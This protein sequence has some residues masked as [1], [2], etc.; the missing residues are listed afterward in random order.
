[1]KQFLNKLSLLIFVL[2]TIVLNKGWSIEKKINFK[3]LTVADG[4]SQGSIYAIY[5]DSRGIMWFGTRGGGLNKYDSYSFQAYKHKANDS[6]SLS[7]DH[8]Y[9]IAETKDGNLWLGT[10]DGLNKYDYNKMSFSHY[11]PVSDQLENISN[12]ILSIII[13]KTNTI[14]LGTRDGLF[15]FNPTSIIFRRHLEGTAIKNIVVNH[16]HVGKDGN[17]WLATE[18]NG[19]I[20]YNTSDRSYRQFKHNPDNTNGI[21][22]NMIKTLFED[23]NKNLWIGGTRLQKITDET[24]GI[25]ENIDFSSLDKNLDNLKVWAITQVNQNELWMG[26]TCGLITYN[27]K[28]KTLQLIQNNPKNSSKELINSIFS[29]KKDAMGNIWIGSSWGGVNLLEKQKSFEWHQF[30]SNSSMNSLSNIVTSFLEDEKQIWI[31]TEHHGILLF[32]LDT[33]RLHSFEKDVD[34]HYNLSK[35]DIRTEYKDQNGNLWLGINGGLNEFNPKK[36][37]FRHF[38]MPFNVTAI[39][40]TTPHMMWLGTSSGLYHFNTQTKKYHLVKDNTSSIDFSNKFIKNILLDS[41]KRLWIGTANEGII[42]HDPSQNTF[43][44]YKMKGSISGLSANT[45]TSIR[46]DDLGEIWAGTQ[47]GI[48]KYDSYMDQFLYPDFNEKLIDLQIKCILSD[49]N[50]D[51]WISS[52]QGITKMNPQTNEMHVYGFS[53]GLQ[54]NDFFEGACLETSDGEM[55]FGGLSGFNIFHPDTIFEDYASIPLIF[56]DFKIEYQ[57]MLPGEKDSPL[58]N[59]IN[60]TKKVNL[61]FDQN[62]I[63]I[64][65]TAIDYHNSKKIQYSYFLE[66]FD[67]EWVMSGDKR[68]AAYT[69]IPPGNYKFRLKK[70]NNYGVWDEQERLLQI[71]IKPPFWKTTI[72]IVFYIIL[73]VLFLLGFR[74]IT[75]T[76]TEQKNLLVNERMENERIKEMNNMKLRFFTNISHEFRTPLS[77]IIG[78]IE[79]L[80]SISDEALNNESLLLIIKRNARILQNLIN[81]L[82]DFRKLETGN[83]KLIIKKTDINRFISNS[84]DSFKSIAIENEIGF[85]IRIPSEKEEI[86]FDQDK[87]L[88]IL[89]NLLSNSFKYTP[90]TWKVFL[91]VSTHA[92]PQNKFLKNDLIIS[93][94]ESP[95]KEFV[96]LVVEDSG[97]GLSADQIPKIFDRYYQAEGSTGICEPGSGVGLALVKNLVLLM[98]GEILVAGEKGVGS[99]FTVRLPMIREYE[100]E[101]SGSEILPDLADNLFLPEYSGQEYAFDE[102]IKSLPS[103]KHM[104]DG[105]L[106]YRVLI[107]E[108]NTDLRTFLKD[109]LSEHFLI[110]EAADGEEGIR[111]ALQ[112]VPDLIL[113]DV[114]MPNMS[115]TELC[116]KIKMDTLTSHIPVVLLTALTSLE[117]TFEGL[118]TGADLYIPKPFNVNIILLQIQ[119]IIKSREALRQRFKKESFLHPSE[120]TVTSLDEEFLN[121]AMAYVEKHMDDENLSVK[122]FHEEMA[123][124]RSNL[125][126]K[127]KALTGL[128]PN[129]YIRTIRLNRAAQLLLNSG[130]TIVEIA[131]ETGFNS[132]SYFSKSFKAQFNMSPNAYV[133]HK[134]RS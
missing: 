18:K 133:K 102:P 123:M 88:K 119:N 115:G 1:M 83:M 3:K 4:L 26:T 23:H 72:A 107:V 66:G 45:I 40:Q 47:N 61:K 111:I 116:K 69:N 39:E 82:M 113:S 125:Q 134:S 60:N 27:V 35:Y 122:S 118:E 109:S 64:N 117:H 81:E 87:L 101:K 90:K 15:S 16:I 44:L 37:T 12:I 89:Y 38:A 62:S 86:Y 58:M 31:G 55:F 11:F 112:T 54:N 28:D 128:S 43:I 46:E 68:S 76:R 84:C 63:G 48:Y 74:Q 85:D 65:F 132:P 77:L 57:S 49:N 10:K 114:M 13:D 79:K 56:T 5:Q 129:E 25:F 73:F 32:D 17:L 67:N 8:V 6:T 131:Y 110:T 75:I 53:D 98:K 121:K 50:N 78:P 41:N 34:V 104:S 24:A 99:R 2:F 7:S 124:S 9:C 93:S 127:I 59:H 108:D 95:L 120:I 105:D 22:S 106:K 92:I 51:L 126:L 21:S 130:L 19:L 52:N 36:R 71:R 103:F 97:L 14:W 96:E 29:M 33:R 42:L 70:T 20:H 94:N 30:Q 80:I 91:S 100:P